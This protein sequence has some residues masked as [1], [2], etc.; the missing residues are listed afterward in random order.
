VRAPFAVTFDEMLK[1]VV[2]SKYGLAAN[3]VEKLKQVFDQIDKDGSV[4]DHAEGMGWAGGVCLSCTN[5][6]Y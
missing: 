6:D 5:F 3:R 1:A 2:S 4:S